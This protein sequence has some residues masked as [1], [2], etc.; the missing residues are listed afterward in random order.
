MLQRAG[1][2]GEGRKEIMKRERKGEREKGRKDGGKEDKFGYNGNEYT[3]RLGKITIF[4]INSNQ[5]GA[6]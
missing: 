1:E 6:K 4:L 5:Q 3:V 2:R